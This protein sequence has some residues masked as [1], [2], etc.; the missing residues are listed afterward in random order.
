MLAA[1]QIMIKL[2]P[3]RR[4]AALLGPATSAPPREDAPTERGQTAAV[5]AALDTAS[6]HLGWKVVC[7]PRA[8]AAKWMLARRG[9]ASTLQL[10]ICRAT[11]NGSGT[12]LHAWLSVGGEVIV[13]GEG[14]ERFVV[15][16]YYGARRPLPAK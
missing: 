14:A 2:V 6:R 5:V 16:A 7:L 4:W 11:A 13:G 3:Y 8:M 10:G 9:I 12:A 1:A 15:L